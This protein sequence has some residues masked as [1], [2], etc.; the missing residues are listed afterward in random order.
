MLPVE[1]ARRLHRVAL[2]AED[3]PGELLQD[4]RDTDR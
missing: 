2:G 4:Q 3:V 1:P